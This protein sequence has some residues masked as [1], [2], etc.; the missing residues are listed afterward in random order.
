MSFPITDLDSLDALFSDPT[1]EST[2]VVPAWY[3]LTF[4]PGRIIPLRVTFALFGCIP[5]CCTAYRPK[6]SVDLNWTLW[7]SD[8]PNTKARLS[9]HWLAFKTQV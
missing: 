2:A 6:K 3:H 4:S 9:C 5:S 8:N 1:G 7:V